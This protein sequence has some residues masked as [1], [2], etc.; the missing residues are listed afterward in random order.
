MVVTCGL[1]H[2][3]PERGHRRGVPPAPPLSD[4]PLRPPRPRRR[5]AGPPRRATASAG[6]ATSAPCGPRARSSSRPIFGEHLLL[7]RRVEARVGESAVHD[8]RRGGERRPPPDVRTCCCTTATSA[9]RSS[10]RDPSCSSR[11][12]ET[13]T[14]YGVP[15]EGYRTLSAPD[16]GLHRGLLRARARRRGRRGTVP[17]ALVNRALG[18]GVYQVFR[19]DQLAAPHGLADDGRGHLRDG[20]GAQHEPRRRSL[21]RHASAASCSSSSRARPAR[22]DLEI[23]ALDGAEAIEAFE[24]RV[25][26]HPRHRRSEPRPPRRRR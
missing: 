17:V 24:A 22:Y 8:P 3:G 5:A 9:S 10:T 23:G 7:R 6:T 11:P 15:I 21:G 14:D 18:I 2:L 12:R 26:G 1:D 20:P 19:I 4:R 13:T 25:A 16:P